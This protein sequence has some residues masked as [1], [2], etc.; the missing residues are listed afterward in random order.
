MRFENPTVADIFRHRGDQFLQAFS[1][2]L[3]PVALKAFAAIRM[4]RT[5]ALGARF[6]I[7]RHCDTHHVLYN[8]CRNRHCPACQS[9]AAS[10]WLNRQLSRIVPAPYFHIVFTLPP[11]IATIAFYNRRLVLGILMKTSAETITTIAA[12]PKRFG[13]HV[14]GTAVLH[15]WNQQLQWHPHSHVL[16]ANAGFDV[17]TGQYITGSATFFAP[18]KVLAAYFRRR[19]LE[20]LQLAYR[21]NQ[22]RFPGA[23]ASVESP[24]AFQRLIKRARTTEW[25]VYAKPPFAGPRQLLRYLSRYTHRVAIGNSRIL[26]FDG[27]SVWLRY[28]K[29]TRRGQAKPTYGVMTLPAVEFIRRY[30]THVLPARF[31]RIRHFGIL[32][33]SKAR[34]TLEHIQ[35]ETGFR[36]DGQILPD[37]LKDEAGNVQAAAPACPR[38]QTPMWFV[39][40]CRPEDP[41]TDTL[42]FYQVRAPPL[43]SAA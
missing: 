11:A 4:C 22:L 31:H 1:T 26:R 25:K 14:G 16:V 23:S 12:D 42:D 24:K 17:D 33:N 10:H 29:P 37:H 3:G 28:R 36:A 34:Q 39:G 15:S 35:L 41:L 8:S 21:N 13:A 32:A 18:V 30:L 20:Q 38:C 7:C 6:F 43:P 40:F 2:R 5:P 19:F 9:S 27:D